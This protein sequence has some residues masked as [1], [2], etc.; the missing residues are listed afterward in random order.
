MGEPSAADFEDWKY[1]ATERVVSPEF[2]LA[3]IISD[4]LHTLDG[5]QALAWHMARGLSERIA[6]TVVSYQHI[7]AAL[8][9]PLPDPTEGTLADA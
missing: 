6:E 5:V 2:Q 9:E 1:R 3:V 4:F 7:T 8:A